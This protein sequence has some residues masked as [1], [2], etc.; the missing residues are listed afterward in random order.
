MATTEVAKLEVEETEL[1]K[2]ISK[3]EAELTRLEAA[4]TE[5]KKNIARILKDISHLESK[6]P[7]VVALG[8]Y[9]KMRLEA[10]RLYKEQAS[11]E[12]N[13]REQTKRLKGLC[14]NLKS[15]QESLRS[16]RKL[17]SV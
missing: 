12:M 4:R 3:A 6:G 7:R 14:R 17:R 10:L 9:K 1:K 11:N 16:S 8:E 13:I 2:A 5:T 15:T